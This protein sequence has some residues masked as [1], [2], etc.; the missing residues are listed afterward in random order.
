MSSWA[1]C[2]ERAR[3]K[4][5]ETVLVNGATGMAGRLAL[6]IAKH[7]G[8]RKVI[9]TGRNADALRSLAALGADVTIPLVESESVLEDSLKNSS[10]MGWMSS[11]TIC[12][13]RVRSA[14]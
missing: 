12:G 3:L 7:L 8:A 11:S 9:A 5:G 14:F 13:G 6:Q 2:R 4:V 10:P 1:A